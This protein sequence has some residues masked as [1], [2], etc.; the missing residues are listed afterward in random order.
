MLHFY[1][2]LSGPVPIFTHSPFFKW[3]V[4]GRWSL[5]A[6]S[7]FQCGDQTLIIVIIFCLIFSVVF[8]YR[9]LKAC[10][11]QSNHKDRGRLSL[12]SH[13]LEDFCFIPHQTF[14]L[15]NK[16]SKQLGIQKDYCTKLLDLCILFLY[17]IQSIKGIENGFNCLSRHVHSSIFHVGCTN[18]IR[19]LYKFSRS[20]PVISVVKSLIGTSLN[21]LQMLVFF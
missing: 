6:N 19:Q 10:L 14:V 3:V 12:I 9:I 16:S 8:P 1:L 15:R 21:F 11:Y 18:G 4:V 7:Y 17:I 13:Y 5:I 20:R 2:Q